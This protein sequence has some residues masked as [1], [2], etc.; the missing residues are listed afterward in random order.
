MYNN[1]IL[2]ESIAVGGGENKAAAFWPMDGKSGSFD[3]YTK[4][5]D[6][7]TKPILLVPVSFVTTH[8][9][10]ADFIP[11]TSSVPEQNGK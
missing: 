1:T 2:H 8:T 4:P 9:L 6:N 7:Y 10:F 5:F 11:V 3:N